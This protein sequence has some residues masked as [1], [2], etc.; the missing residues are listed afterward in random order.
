MEQLPAPAPKLTKKNRLFCQ[1]VLAGNPVP[2]AHKMAGYTGDAHAAYEL[3]SKLRGFIRA[4]AERR[5]VSLEGIAADIAALDSLPLTDTT[6]TVKDKLAIIKAKHH[7]VEST[8]PKTKV[9]LKGLVFEADGEDVV[10]V[11]AE[12]VTESKEDADRGEHGSQGQEVGEA[13]GQQDVPAPDA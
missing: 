10:D 9:T 5:G 7:F 1:L 13:V 4:E 12:D 2:V 6:V 3:K 11:E 8:E